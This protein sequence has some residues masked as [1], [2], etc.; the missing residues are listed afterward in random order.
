M[1][2]PDA[3]TK[4][5]RRLVFPRVIINEGQ[6]YNRNDGVFTAPVGGLFVFYSSLISYGNEPFGCDLVLND[7]AKVQ[8]YT[9]A[10]ANLG[11]Q[12]ASNMVVLRLQ[13]G[14]RIWMKVATA[15]RVNANPT[16]SISTFSGYLIPILHS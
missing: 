3:S 15:N 16:S 14:D 8:V 5:G 2:T 12:P 11:T 4:V 7:N 10:N 13:K 9:Y 6:S 1:T